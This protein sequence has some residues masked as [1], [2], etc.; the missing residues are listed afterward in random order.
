MTADLTP[1]VGALDHLVVTTP[2]LSA[3]LDE[4]EQRL[5][6]RPQLGGEH[7]RYGTHNALLALGGDAFVEVIAAQPGVSETD[8]PRPFGLDRGVTETSLCTF[9]AHPDDLED[10]A[11]RL[12]ELGV[13][14][15]PV[16]DGERTAPDG[17]RLTWRL[18]GPLAG[19]S[20]AVEP[21][22]VVPFLIDWQDTTSPAHTVSAR[23]QLTGWGVSSPDAD[24]VRG[25]LATVGVPLPVTDGEPALW[26]ELEGPAGRWRLG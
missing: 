14:V 18:T 7:P 12:R 25:L 3:A 8:L 20:A 22:G 19:V 5:G 6:V 26:I 10:A 1:A 16:E 13:D 9:A 11:D 2:D 4:F 17:T 23:V 15:G 24:R 21:A